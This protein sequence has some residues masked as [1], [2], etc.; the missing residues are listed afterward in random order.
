MRLRTVALMGALALAC[1]CGNK[2]E[3]ANRMFELGMSYVAQQ[4][5]TA[6]SQSFERAVQL[7]PK[8]AAARRNLADAYVFLQRYDEAVREFEK[9]IELEPRFTEEGYIKASIARERQNRIAEAIH[10]LER[11]VQASP[12]HMGVRLQLGHL[13]WREMRLPEAR[14]QFTRAITVMPMNSPGFNGLGIVFAASGQHV[15]AMEAF[16]RAAQIDPQNAM[17]VHNLALEHLSLRAFAEA[18]KCLRESLA[19]APNYLTA[20]V[21][22]AR[23]LEEQ[24]RLD[25]ALASYERVLKDEPRNAFILSKAGNVLLKQGK[26]DEAVERLKLA[27]ECYPRDSYLDGTSAHHL[28][29]MAYAK[30]NKPAEALAEYEKATK[31][32]PACLEAKKALAEVYQKEG[33]AKEAEDLKKDV[34]TFE[35]RFGEKKKAAELYFEG[36]GA[37]RGKKYAEAEAKFREAVKLAP[38][39][40][41][42]HEDL[43]RTLFALNKLEDA[44][45][46][47]EAVTEKDREAVDSLHY[48][49]LIAQKTGRDA[50]ALELLRTVTNIAPYKHQAHV[51]FGDLLLAGGKTDEALRA[52]DDAV[53][54]RPDWK[55]G[56]EMVAKAYEKA[57]KPEDAQ[58]RR[59][60]L[61]RLLEPPPAPAP[62]QEQAGKP[63]KSPP[64]PTQS[65]KLPEDAGKT[66][67]APEPPKPQ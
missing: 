7:A 14:R 4:N 66:G 65:P 29:G 57:G 43:G 63:S 38:E 21:N 5:F 59:D 9:A 1:G 67:K 11:V 13:Y 16:E 41:G 19:L 30:L 24:G 50:E 33:K 31:A 42:I 8:H 25:E 15:A 45:K 3:E 20:H 32:N 17:V 27:L 60:A 40:P 46:E 10:Y 54:F 48:L 28:L 23:V 56:Y 34:E 62:G 55:E 58:K 36:V 39:F 44:K 26:P 35:S 37:L 61:K 47:F 18:E 49:A 2:E 6:A 51:E 22:L 53:R 12:S 64:L 52:Y